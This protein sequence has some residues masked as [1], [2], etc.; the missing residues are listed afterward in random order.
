MSVRTRRSRLL[1][2]C[3]A[4]AAAVLLTVPASTEATEDLTKAPGFRAVDLQGERFTLDDLLGKGPIV[5]DFWA[6]WCKPCIKELPYVQRL[7]EDYRDRG[8]QVLAVTIDSPKSQSQVR[9]FIKSR[10]YD[11]RVVMDA[12]QDV[13]RKLQGKGTIPYVVILDE[14]GYIRYHHTGYRPGDEKE[15]TRVVKELLAEAG[16]S[17]GASD[18]REESTEVGETDSGEAGAEG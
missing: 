16:E 4:L 10:K 2:N 17:D 14:N 13:F 11:F 8:V 1:G 9:R 15:L 12:E 18:G 7:H 3:A 5:V 6:T